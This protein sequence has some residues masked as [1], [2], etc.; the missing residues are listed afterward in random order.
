MEDLT[1]WWLFP[2][3]MWWGFLV[4]VIPYTI[5]HYIGRKGE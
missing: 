3:G 5:G 4:T 1:N 2:L